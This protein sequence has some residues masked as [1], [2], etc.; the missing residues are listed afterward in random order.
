LNRP[1]HFSDA[2]RAEC[3]RRQAEHDDLMAQVAEREAQMEHDLTDEEYELGSAAC[4][5]PE[6]SPPYPLPPQHSPA[7]RRRNYGR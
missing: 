1:V 3:Q 7:S 5:E 2:D 4:T 6:C